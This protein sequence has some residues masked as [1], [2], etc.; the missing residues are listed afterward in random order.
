MADLTALQ[1]DV[2][3]A[4]AGIDSPNGQDIRRELADSQ[5]RDILSGHIYLNLE[6]LVDKGL[7]EKSARNGRSNEYALT[8]DGE[9]WLDDRLEW[10]QTY[11]SFERATCE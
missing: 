1:R 6:Q 11:V 4:V 8:A 9:S 5:G 7:I 3:F 10:E 2:L